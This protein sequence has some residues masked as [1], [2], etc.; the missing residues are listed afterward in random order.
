MT[1]MASLKASLLQLGETGVL[2]RVVALTGYPNEDRS[3][4]LNMEQDMMLI[5]DRTIH[6]LQQHGYQVEKRDG[7]SIVPFTAQQVLEGID[8][9]VDYDSLPV[10]DPLRQE[11]D[12]IWQPAA[13][14]LGLVR[15]GEVLVGTFPLVSLCEDSFVNRTGKTPHDRGYIYSR[16]LR[17]DMETAEFLDNIEPAKRPDYTLIQGE[18]LLEPYKS[19][20]VSTVAH[21]DFRAGSLQHIER[22]VEE[23]YLLSFT[24]APKTLMHEFGLTLKI[25][26]SVVTVVRKSDG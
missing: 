24:D 1:E 7:I 25:P 22:T 9:G 13:S 19:R 14:Q 11:R 26:E 16:S 17:P 20:V 3:Q 10:D 6:I 21:V 2:T 5:Q 12:E 8:V 18:L 23:Q 4:V 15:E